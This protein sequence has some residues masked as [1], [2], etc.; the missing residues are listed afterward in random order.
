[1]HCY[2]IMSEMITKKYTN[3]TKNRIYR[4]RLRLF[5]TSSWP[6]LWHEDQILKEIRLTTGLRW[7]ALKSLSYELIIFSVPFISAIQISSL[8]WHPNVKVKILW[9]CKQNKTAPST[10]Q[11][12]SVDASIMVS[13]NHWWPRCCH[14]RDT[15]GYHSSSITC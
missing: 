2:L 8:T 5:L 7:N 15:K 14:F 12:L 4:S 9:R 10:F 3:F 6:R 1:L 11:D 13:F